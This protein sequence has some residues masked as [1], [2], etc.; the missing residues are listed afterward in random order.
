MS[1]ALS[2]GLKQRFVLCS[3]LRY[4]GPMRC[5]LRTVVALPLEAKRHPISGSAC[6][7][8]DCRPC[9]RAPPAR[10]I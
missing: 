8:R 6:G 7:S 1:T 5:R 4:R 9:S 10:I 2:G 3:G